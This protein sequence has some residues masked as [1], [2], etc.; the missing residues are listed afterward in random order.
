MPY[1]GISGLGTKQQA[2]TTNTATL[3]RSLISTA[4]Y[5]KQKSYT[6]AYSLAELGFRRAPNNFH[7]AHSRVLPALSDISLERI[8]RKDL[9]VILPSEARF[10]ITMNGTLL[11]DCHVYEVERVTE[12]IFV[13]L[14]RTDLNEECTPE[15]MF[16]LRN[17]LNP[18]K[19]V[20][21][22]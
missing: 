17:N 10:L 14:H 19:S 9:F 13:R 2:N 4:V 1:P 8:S 5:V 12:H 22:H 21:A 11:D 6:H 18:E 20:P 7:G 15:N 16:I 3:G